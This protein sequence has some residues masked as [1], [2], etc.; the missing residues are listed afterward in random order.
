LILQNNSQR[1]FA[2]A[3]G[4]RKPAGVKEEIIRSE[5]KEQEKRVHE[6]VYES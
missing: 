3:L 1:K 6:A 4:E 2:E 5:E